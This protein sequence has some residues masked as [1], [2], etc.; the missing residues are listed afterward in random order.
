MSLIDR[1]KWWDNWV[2]KYLPNHSLETDERLEQL[3]L[4][5]RELAC[6]YI[7]EKIKSFFHL[8]K[9][10]YI[11]VKFEEYSNS[12]PSIIIKLPYKNDIYDTFYVFFNRDN[13]YGHIRIWL[14]TSNDYHTC[15]S[16]SHKKNTEII[17]RLQEYL[18]V[19]EITRM[20]NFP[21]YH[22]HRVIT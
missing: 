20:V 1:P 18:P 14:P 12:N 11:S 7:E 8:N 19:D 17:Q 2:D 10:K 16:G 22:Q 9:I 21:F 15:Y 5:C 13:W 6:N 4:T 3:H